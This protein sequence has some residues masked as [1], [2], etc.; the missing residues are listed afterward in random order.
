V[1]QATGPDF[2]RK[3]ANW[4]RGRSELLLRRWGDGAAAAIAAIASRV[5]P[6]VLVADSTFVLPVLP[7]GPWPLLLHLHNIESAVF[8]RSDT[9]RRSFADRVTRQFEARSIA[10][11]ERTALQRAAASITVSDLDRAMALALA[12]QANVITVPNSVDLDRLPLLPPAPPGPPRLLFV[13][14]VDYPPNHEAIVELIEQHLPGLRAA[15]PGLV[16]RLVG[17]DDGGRLAAFR[18]RE[19]VEAIGPVDDLLPHY[20]ASHAVYLPIRSGGGTRIK[21]LEA[22]ALGR[23]VLSS[24]IGAEGLGGSD[25]EHWRRVESVQQGIAALRDV[26]AGQGAALVGKARALVQG[27][28]SHRAAIESLRQI[29][30]SVTRV[31]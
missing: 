6:E 8:A 4:A 25:G 13:G 18:G 2:A 9:T 22:W 14:T 27:R 26:L 29:V 10:A 23:P 1:P 5:R 15:F 11:A 16:V 30:R 31:R 12:P 3:L 21:I 17:R 7:S 20:A 24:G 19:G 28:F